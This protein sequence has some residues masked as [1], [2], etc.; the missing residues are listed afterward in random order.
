MQLV[1]DIPDLLTK[2]ELLSNYSAV[3][4]HNHIIGHSLHTV[5]LKIN[6]I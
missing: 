4:V 2:Y 6:I 3:K 1:C 5:F